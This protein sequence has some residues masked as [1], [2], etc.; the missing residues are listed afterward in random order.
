MLKAKELRKLHAA[1]YLLPGEDILLAFESA[2]KEFAFT[3]ES[4][5][6]IRGESATTTRKLVQRYS[7]QECL[8][9]KIQFET[10]GRMDRDCEVSFNIGDK[11]VS[12][13]I[14]WK[15]EECGKGVYKMLLRLAREQ[16]AR[17]WSWKQAQK[18]LD[19]AANKLSIKTGDG[20]VSQATTAVAWL[21]H[22]FT[23]RNQRCYREVITSAMAE[24][25]VKSN[26]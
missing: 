25:I 4:F 16:N 15:E 8:I 7:Y 2:K 12:I 6:L 20:L 24:T 14:T 3:N 11:N 17:S 21:E 26:M 18:C 1:S 13:T 22:A 9:S 19:K 23:E 5:I 10:T